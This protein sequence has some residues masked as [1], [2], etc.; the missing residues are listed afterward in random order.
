MC[1]LIT[2]KLGNTKPMF[3]ISTG[4]PQLTTSIELKISDA[5]EI[6]LK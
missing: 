6:V 5:K 3:K 2:I 1:G 4:N